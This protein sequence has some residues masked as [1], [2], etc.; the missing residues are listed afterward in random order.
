M[1]LAL[2]N[3]RW[4]EIQRLRSELDALHK[5]VCNLRLRAAEYQWDV[6]LANNQ[7]DAEVEERIRLQQYVTNLEAEVR[8]PQR[9]LLEAWGR[10]REVIERTG[11][12]FWFG[13]DLVR[14]AIMEDPKKPA[15]KPTPGIQV[16]TEDLKK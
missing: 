4:D 15:P 7:R 2:S 10:V 11:T 6:K 3:A 12:P 5:Q 14:A 9:V 16:V 13:W 1:S 8:K